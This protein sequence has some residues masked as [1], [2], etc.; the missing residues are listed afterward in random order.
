MPT[1]AE[2]RSLIEE[3]KKAYEQEELM[4]AKK[5]IESKVEQLLTV[6]EN[7]DLMKRFG[8]SITNLLEKVG[9]YEEAKQVFEKYY[10]EIKHPP[11]RTKRYRAGISPYYK[12]P[13]Q[14]QDEAMQKRDIEILESIRFKYK[15]QNEFSWCGIHEKK[16]IDGLCP[17]SKKTL[18]YPHSLDSIEFKWRRI[19]HTTCIAANG[20]SVKPSFD[21]S[22][23]ISGELWKVRLTLTNLNDR[24]RDLQIELGSCDHLTLK[25]CTLT[26]SN[27]ENYPLILNEHNSL[28]KE[29]KN[30]AIRT[31]EKDDIFTINFTFLVKVNSGTKI[32][33]SLD[34]FFKIKYS[35]FEDSC[36]TIPLT[37]YPAC[38]LLLPKI[39]EYFK[40]EIWSEIEGFIEFCE[41]SKELKDKAYLTFEP[42]REL[43][44]KLLKE[45]GDQKIINYEINK[46]Q[47]EFR[48]TNFDEVS[49][50][51]FETEGVLSEE[52]RYYRRDI[53]EH[54]KPVEV[55]QKRELEEVKVGQIDITRK[56]NILSDRFL[57]FVRVEN[58]HSDIAIHDVQVHL[59]LPDSL[60]VSEGTS[61][62]DKLGRIKAHED[63]AAK[64]FVECGV[65]CKRGDEINATILYNDEKGNL[66]RVPMEPYLIDRC[67]YTE[68]VELG[69]E[70]VETLKTQSKEE[71]IYVDPDMVP[72]MSL[73]KFQDLLQ[74]NLNMRPKRINANS[75]QFMGQTLK[76]QE[77]LLIETTL[78]ANGYSFNLYGNEQNQI[79]LATVLQCII[80]DVIRAE[81]RDLKDWLSEKLTYL[82]TVNRDTYNQVKINTHI[83]YLL[84]EKAT[85][86]T[87]QRFFKN[88][89]KMI[90]NKT[91]TVDQVNETLH[92]FKAALEDHLMMKNLLEKSKWGKFLDYLKSGFKF[93][94]GEVFG[95]LIGK[96]ID[97]IINLIQEHLSH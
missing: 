64:F 84:E 29:G 49:M 23:L 94:L 92:Y 72:D 13:Q 37:I 35:D 85:A 43:L 61:E 8:E 55:E 6:L 54:E 77:P 44:E 42:S 90:E 28:I 81:V 83:P 47:N 2:F 70:E 14:V 7:N 10:W 91:L 38:E 87:L 30:W 11:G 63:G 56:L 26:P 17:E 88:L 97:G 78:N 33:C 89:G 22:E 71:T 51:E 74:N 12:D 66:Q 21:S 19:K 96:G 76:T 46:P 60:K 57:F 39:V 24:I 41:V 86:K 93:T 79:G 69:K 59:I 32:G 65:M 45:L 75:I 31:A 16:L 36:P 80:R 27:K 82:E 62:I 52:E 50:L 3:C 40:K 9:K 20:I 58:L 48:L 68:S 25:E 5:F 34:N 53:I 73:K 67:V 15:H 4:D 1:E 18:I 95:T